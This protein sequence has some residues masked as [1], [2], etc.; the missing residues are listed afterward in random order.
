MT[1]EDSNI[2]YVIILNWLRWE[3]TIPCLESVLKL[4][5]DHYRIIIC[6]NNS[7]NESVTQITAWLDGRLALDF[8]GDP[9]SDLINPCV[10]K[11]VAYQ[12]LQE[13]ELGKAGADDPPVTI[14]RNQ[15]NHG[16]AGGNN[17]GI[18]YALSDPRCSATW[19]LNNDVVV[20]PNSLNPLVAA[21]DDV[22]GIIGS[23]VLNYAEGDLQMP[24]G[25][26]YNRYSGKSDFLP[27]DGALEHR[28]L[29]YIAGCSM[30]L[31]RS[32][33]EKVGLLCEDYFLFYEEFD[34]TLRAKKQGFGIKYVPTSVVYHKQAATTG[35]TGLVDFYIL[36]NRLIFTRRFFPSYYPSVFISVL[37]TAGMSV[38]LGQPKRGY[39]IFQLAL[40]PDQTYEPERW[41]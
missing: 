26:H 3:E 7:H 16:Y 37:M 8:A 22:T 12:L 4:N 11:P 20:T 40:N 31:T 5:N 29:D 2:V 27:S 15:A 38:L 36:K 13:S 25:A 17:V 34:Y 6:D 24:G 10:P 30:L 23:T 33:I 35:R 32:V 14:I 39:R 28:S 41:E 18:G 21:I 1:R 9:R 19:I